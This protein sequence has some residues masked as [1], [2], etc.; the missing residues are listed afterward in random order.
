MKFLNNFFCLFLF[1]AMVSAALGSVSFTA[2]S[3]D[4]YTERL[5]RKIKNE[6]K[7]NLLYE[8]CFRGKD[9]FSLRMVFSNL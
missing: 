8:V 4:P 7:K 1:N 5:Y 9:K 6:G 2:V 3:D